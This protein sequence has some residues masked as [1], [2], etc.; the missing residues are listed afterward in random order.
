MA[1]K[2]PSLDGLRAMSILLVLGAHAAATRGF[3]AE[4]A[5]VTKH[6]LVGELGVRVFFV[7]SGFLITHLLLREEATRGTSSIPLF[8]ARRALRILPVYFAFV[9]VF[10][11]L[12]WR[13]PLGA[14]ADEY[15]AMLLFAKNFVPGHGINDHLWSLAVEEQFYLVW[16]LVLC[17]PRRGRL[18]AAG[19]ALVL[20]PL[21]RIWAYSTHHETLYRAAPFSHMDSLMLGAL[22]ALLLQVQPDRLRGWLGRHTGWQRAAALAVVV[23]VQAAIN[24]YL[25]ARLTVPLGATLQALATAWFLLS[26]VCVHHGAVYRGLNHPAAVWLGGLSYGLYL[27]QQLFLCSPQV[28]HGND[29]LLPSFPWNVLAA[30]AAAWVSFQV[31]EKPLLAFRARL[32]PGTARG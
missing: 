17:L 3:P 12:D 20:A 24:H 10:A 2:L 11:V 15:A 23:A 1:P 26:V 22:A 6:V 5:E 13:V 7:I 9:A 18:S 25:L 30:L 4:W 16:P 31:L 29:F 19:A 32:R 14:S 27:W 28:Y 21:W 8:Y